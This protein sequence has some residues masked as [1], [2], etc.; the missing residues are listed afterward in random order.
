M[1]LSLKAALEA[2]KA[3]EQALG[4]VHRLDRSVGE[5]ALVRIAMRTGQDGFVGTTGSV[6]EGGHRVPPIGVCA[7]TMLKRCKS[8]QPAAFLALFGE[9]TPIRR[10]DLR[11]NQSPRR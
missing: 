3:G 6:Y 2:E 7:E 4:L 9:P 8:A 1:G 5:E 11:V 10:D